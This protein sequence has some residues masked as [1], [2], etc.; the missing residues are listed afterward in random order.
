MMGG[1]RGVVVKKERKKEREG[2]MAISLSLLAY[3]K[4]KEREK[5]MENKESVLKK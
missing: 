3:I 4:N 5:L 1:R 2:R